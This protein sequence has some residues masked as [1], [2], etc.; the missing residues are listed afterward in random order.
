MKIGKPLSIAFLVVVLI[1]TAQHL[2]LIANYVEYKDA[3]QQTD[4]LALQFP[5]NSVILYPANDVYAEW[6]AVPLR[7]EHGLN[8]IPVQR[9]DQHVIDAVNT[10]LA[11]RLHVYLLHVPE[12]QASQFS[13]H[14]AV[15]KVTT[16]TLSYVLL[17]GPY[18]F[19]PTRVATVM[20]AY[21]IIELKSP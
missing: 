6:V 18:G 8:P 16:V 1:L 21:P 20:I 13:A 7:Y 15:Q 11:E 12:N 3:L 4:A 9:F 17:T 5:A 2:P 14:F 19:F 10:W